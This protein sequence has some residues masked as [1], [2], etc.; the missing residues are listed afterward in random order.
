MNLTRWLLVGLSGS[1]KGREF[2]LIADEI[3]IGRTEE[4]DII[5]PEKPVSRHHAT[6]FVQDT[7][8]L[9]QDMNSKN[10]TFVNQ[11]KVTK[12]AI[13]LNDVLKIGDSRFKVANEE[14]VASKKVLRELWNH[15][16]LKIIGFSPAKRWTV[17]GTLLFLL[18]LL[19]WLMSNTSDQMPVENEP[20]M[21]LKH[22]DD[23]EPTPALTNMEATDQ[24]V[25]EWLSQADAVM[26]Y[27]DY[28]KA[29][30]YLQKVVAARP[31]DTSSRAKLNQMDVKLRARIAMYDENGA[32]EYEKL[33]YERAINEWRIVMA[34]TKN[35]DQSTYENTRLK[36]KDA[37]EQLRI[38]SK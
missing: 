32:R 23:L 8:L 33:N 1:V 9:L 19:G 34:L 24:Q 20:N 16:R 36:I 22:I 4:N 15:A 11:Q 27:D 21:T 3:R 38:R 26:Q 25:S 35:F 14:H 2:V 10:G 29:I 18:V 6:L 30:E 17:F 12:L 31:G 13:N 28:N 37:E 5:I 7:G